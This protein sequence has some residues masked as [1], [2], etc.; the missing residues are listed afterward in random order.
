MAKEDMRSG[1]NNQ[2]EDPIG[3][4]LEGNHRE[5][6]NFATKSQGIHSTIKSYLSRMT[7][8]IFDETARD[9]GDYVRIHTPFESGKMTF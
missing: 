6:S 7:A 2:A 8:L 4:R 9:G 1:H 3:Y 5:V